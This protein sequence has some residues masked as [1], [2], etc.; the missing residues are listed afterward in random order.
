MNPNAGRTCGYQ[1]GLCTSAVTAVVTG[2]LAAI[3]LGMCTPACAQDL[4]ADPGAALQAK[5]LELQPQLR[6]NA[7][8]EPLYLSSH[9]DDHQMEGDVYAEVGHPFTRV[10]A[11]FKSATT[12]CELLFLHLNVRACQP[13]VT[14][15]GEVLTLSVGP[16]RALAPGMLYRMS[17]AL[18]AE[19]ATAAYLRVTLTAPEGP[20]STHDY[21]IVFEAV[22][23]DGSRSFVH[24]GYTYGY[25]MMAKIAMEVYLAT[26]GRSKIGFT[27]VGQSTDGK[28]LYVH[29]ER[30]SL[31]RNVIRYYLALLAHSSVNTGSPQAQMEAQLRAW[32]ALT[33]RYAAQLHELDLDEYLH[34]KHDDL[35]RAASRAK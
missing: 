4:P 3:L 20:L 2:A 34:E 9:E 7:F 29:G 1:R 33:E 23:I 28:P 17:Y 35:A 19:V 27:V 18:R 10:G 16:K 8:G 24:L 31:E 12:V 32:F 22:P 6:A 5:R 15:N 13:S 30:G 26:A 25:G 11:T 14:A 21:R